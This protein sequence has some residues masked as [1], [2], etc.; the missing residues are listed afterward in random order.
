M[1]GVLRVKTVREGHAGGDACVLQRVKDGAF[2]DPVQA[3]GL[4][5]GKV[6]PQVDDEVV[7][8]VLGDG[9]TGGHRDVDRLGGQKLWYG[10][11]GRVGASPRR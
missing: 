10:T 1:P 11:R 7:G 3:A 8:V 6:S 4:G 9:N 5:A 2:D